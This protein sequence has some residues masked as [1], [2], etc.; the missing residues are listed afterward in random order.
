M[1]RTVKGIFVPIEIWEAKDLSWNEKIVFLEIDS[2]TRK[3]RDCYFSDEYITDLLGCSIATAKRVISGLIQKGYVK[4]TRFDGRRRYV[5]TCLCYGRVDD[6]RAAVSKMSEL[7]YQ[8]CA[9][10]EYNLPDI[11]PI[12]S[13]EDSPRG[14]SSLSKAISD[15]NQARQGNPSPE[16]RAA[17]SPKKDFNTSDFVQGLVDIGVDEQVARDWVKQ[18]AAKRLSQ[19]STALNQAIREFNKIPD[20]TPNELILFAIERGWGGFKAE[21]FNNDVNRKKHDNGRNFNSSTADA[22]LLKDGRKREYFDHFL[23]P[24]E[25]LGNKGNTF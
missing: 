10:T 17:P 8:N 15:T 2:F 18:R 16:F 7:G 3:G 14:D 22:L 11:P 12:S 6:E 1:E 13:N 9:T 24:D 4:K 19:T 21:W 5:E 23:S 25:L 20:R